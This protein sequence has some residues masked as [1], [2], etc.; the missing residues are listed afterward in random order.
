M[1]MLLLITE[2]TAKAEVYRNQEFGIDVVLPTGLPMC[3]GAKDQH[4]HGVTI[5]LN[6][7]DGSSCGALEHYRSISIFAAYNVTDDTKTLKDYLRWTCSEVLQ[8]HCA[9]GPKNLK[10]DALHSLSRRVSR[11]DGSIDIVVLTQA[12]RAPNQPVNDRSAFVNYSVRLHTD[13]AHLLADLRSLHRFLRAV[14]LTP[15]G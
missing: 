10:I 6:P 11:P 9:A 13:Q 4:D 2:S 5:F 3:S 14:K 1:A 8:G 15:P 7:K 12:G